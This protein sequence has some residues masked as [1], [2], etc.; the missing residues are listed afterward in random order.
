MSTRVVHC[1]REKYDVYIGRA[2]P[3]FG[4]KAAK[5]GNPFRVSALDGSRQEVIAKYRKWFMMQPQL[6]T[7]LSELRGRVLG[8]WCK[9][10]PCHGD[11]LAELAD[12]LTPE[13]EEP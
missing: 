3:R 11:V 10:L 9:P 12:S 5:W 7:T 4:M 6:L 2:V 1:R 13:K 8:C